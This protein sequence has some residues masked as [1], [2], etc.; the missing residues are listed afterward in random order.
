MKKIGG[1]ISIW[2]LLLLSS[3][4]ASAQGFTYFLSSDTIHYSVGGRIM[5][6]QEWSH[7]EGQEFEHP[8][9][10]PSLEK[11][12][13]VELGDIRKTEKEGVLSF[14]RQAIYTCFDTGYF[15]IQGLP[16]KPSEDS[17]FSNPIFLNIHVAAVDTSEEI[18]DIEN[19]IYVPLTFA[20][21]LPYAL[22]G[23]AIVGFLL[24]IFYFISRK[25]KTE[26]ETQVPH[27]PAHVIAFEKLE[28]VKAEKLWQQDKA[29]EYHFQLSAIIRT[30]IANRFRVPAQDLTTDEL[31]L[32]CENLKI[33]NSLIER[34]RPELN[35]G[36]MVKFAKASL[37][38]EDHEASWE[39]IFTFIKATMQEELKSNVE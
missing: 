11:L 39:I 37:L 34:L 20:E 32:L 1:I 27:R 38:P 14:H 18:K 21:I 9:L 12:E 31:L 15:Q 3:N 7:A 8:D 6:T 17:I 23:I 24:T 13:Q 28:K 19:P 22:G 36:D 30:Y 2:L 29:K 10:P 16:W 5:I 26:E 33:D 25:R 4:L 35:Q